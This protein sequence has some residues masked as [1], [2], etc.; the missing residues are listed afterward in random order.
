M[1]APLLSLYTQDTVVNSFRFNP[2]IAPTCLSN[3][4]IGINSRIAVDNAMYSASVVLSAISVCNFDPQRIGT[5]PKVRTNPVQLLTLLGSWEFSVLHIP[6]KSA[7]AYRSK[8]K[9]FEGLNTIPRVR[10]AFKYQAL[11]FNPCS[12]NRF[13]QCVKRA[14]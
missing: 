14:H 11:C 3:K 10:V 6:A 7:S 2:N 1:S 9:S 13:G 5:S 8:F 12:C 4:Q